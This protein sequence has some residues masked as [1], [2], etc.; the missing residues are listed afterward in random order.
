M[1]GVLLL[2]LTY[3]CNAYSTGAA[4]CTKPGHSGIKLLDGFVFTLN[5]QPNAGTLYVDS[6][7]KITLK[8]S[9]ASFK[10]FLINPKGSGSLTSISS[11]T[12]MMSNTGCTGAITHTNAR[13]GGTL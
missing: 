7:R 5:S 2:V 1:R 12:K 4:S 13:C 11:G 3:Y 6:S 8:L 10:G 9:G